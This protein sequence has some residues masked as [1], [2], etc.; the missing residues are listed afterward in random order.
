MEGLRQIQGGFVER[1]LLDGGP[2]VQDVALRGTTGVEA[3]K[4]IFAEVGRKSSGGIVGVA[5]DRTG[6]APL[7][8]PAAHLFE[9]AEMLQDLRQRDLSTEVGEVDRGTV[10]GS[11]A[12]VHDTVCNQA[13][14]A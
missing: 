5:V 3:A 1:Q 7:T 13:A 8:L 14:W 4:D 2:K 6:A 12:R 9:E 11:S 10:A